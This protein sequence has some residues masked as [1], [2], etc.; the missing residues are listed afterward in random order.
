MPTNGL[1]TLHSTGTW[2]GEFLYHAFTAH[3]TQGGGEGQRQETLLSIVPVPVPCSVSE[4][5]ERGCENISKLAFI[6]FLDVKKEWLHWVSSIWK[7]S[8]C[9]NLSFP[10]LSDSFSWPVQ[11]ENSWRTPNICPLRAHSVFYSTHRLKP[12]SIKNSALELCR[13]YKSQSFAQKIKELDLTGIYT[14][15]VRLFDPKLKARRQV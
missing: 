1:Y 14:G 12:T 10:N 5:W 15:P 11:T 2:N 8:Q 3:T 7:W 6:H 4:P 9:G 13:G